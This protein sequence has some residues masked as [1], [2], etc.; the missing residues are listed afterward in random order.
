MASTNPRLR[1]WIKKAPL[2]LGNLRLSLSIERNVDYSQPVLI[3][4]L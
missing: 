4:R 3:T 2:L 1:V